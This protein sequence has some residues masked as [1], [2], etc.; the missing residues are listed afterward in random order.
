MKKFL[1]FDSGTDQM[2]NASDRMSKWETHESLIAV[3]ELKVNVARLGSA[4]R[5]DGEGY[6]L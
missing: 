4:I 3:E 2:V 1:F 6:Q 5:T